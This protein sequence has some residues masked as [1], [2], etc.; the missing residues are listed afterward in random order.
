MT[1][2]NNHNSAIEEVIKIV[3]LG[4]PN[5]GKSCIVSRYCHDDFTRQY[6]PTI[7]IEFYLK[8]TQIQGRNVRINIWDTSGSS[9]ELLDKYLF[10]ANAIVLV[11]DTT[12]SGSFSAL[13]S[14]HDRTAKAHYENQ[15]KMVLIANKCDLEHKRT[16]AEEKQILFSKEFKVGIT[17]SVSARTGENITNTWQQIAAECLGLKLTKFDLEQNLVKPV[18]AEIET[19]TNQYRTMMSNNKQESST[20]STVCLIQ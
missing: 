4:E 9:N 6:I 1:E 17:Q 11:F 14:W 15:P 7:G 12:D 13:S 16:V 18:R 10:N 3:I 2:T 20:L 5:S 19:T 8:R